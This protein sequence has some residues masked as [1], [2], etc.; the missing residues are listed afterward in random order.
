MEA[1]ATKYMKTFE[2]RET[3]KLTLNLKLNRKE[4]GA[5][6][7]VFQKKEGLSKIDENKGDDEEDNKNINEIYKAKMSKKV[8]CSD[9]LRYFLRLGIEG[10]DKEKLLQ[11]Q[12]QVQKLKKKLLKKAEAA[13]KMSQEVD[14]NFGLNDEQMAL[15]KV[16]IASSKYDRNAPGCVSLD[17]F[18]VDALSVAD[19]KDLIRRVFN[20]NL[21]NK[22]LGFVIQKYDSKKNGTVHCKTFLN[23]FLRLGQEVRHKMHLDQLEKQ[24]KLDALAA[25]ESLPKIKEVQGSETLKIDNNYTEE[26]L[27][28]ALEKIKQAAAFH[29]SERGVSLISFDP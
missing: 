20:L 17:G 27:N 9:F 24:K 26:N 13:Y 23:D 14:Y 10:R 21:T 25:E 4:L 5:V 6:L 18:E 19:F 1:F 2:F 12:K 16:R 11:R 28:T 7:D 29:D 15:E 8:A 22:E 3:L